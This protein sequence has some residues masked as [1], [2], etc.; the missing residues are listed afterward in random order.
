MKTI[1][2]LENFAS[3]G[4]RYKKG[5]IV[6]MEDTQAIKFEKEG[7]VQ[8]LPNVL[9]EQK[10]DIDLSNY[11]TKDELNAIEE[12][13]K[14]E[15]VVTKKMW[16]SLVEKVEKLEKELEKVSAPTPA[17]ATAKTTTKKAS[18]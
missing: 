6:S 10:Q 14:D 18:K 2:V 4:I 9:G 12:K 16:D 15:I 3:Q 11:V 8:A 13:S 7:L 5:Q 17:K 1:Y